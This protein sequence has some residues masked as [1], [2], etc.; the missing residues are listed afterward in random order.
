MKKMAKAAAGQEFVFT[1][2]VAGSP[3]SFSDYLLS[4]L[5]LFAGMFG[6]L[7]VFMSTF[8]VFPADF[9]VLVLLLVPLCLLS[10][11]CWQNRKL[12]FP[13]LLV[14]G[15]GITAVIL[16]FSGQVFSGAIEVYAGV[17][18]VMNG[19][20]YAN[21]A[22][23]YEPVGSGSPLLFWVLVSLVLSLL[24]G[25][26]FIQARSGLL[27]ILVTAP[28]LFFG[29]AF[30]LVPENL[31]FYIL[32][33]SFYVA[34]FSSSR[35]LR[36]G[37][38]GPSLSVGAATLL[39]LFSVLCFLFTQCVFK[40]EEY[41]RA[42]WLVDLRAGTLSFVSSL[43]SG[44][45]PD[46]PFR[47]PG[48]SGGGIAGG[49]LGQIGRLEYTGETAL[50]VTRGVEAPYY[51]R[52]YVGSRYEGNQW[53]QTQ[54]ASRAYLQR[55][56]LS[57]F[58]ETGRDF[59]S[60]G[61][62]ITEQLIRSGSMSV[63]METD[64]VRVEVVNAPGQYRYTPYGS[65]S[66][67]RLDPYNPNFMQ[68]LFQSTGNSTYVEP[69]TLLR[70]TQTGRLVQYS[71]YLDYQHSADYRNAF[72]TVVASLPS[73]TWSDQ[74]ANYVSAY[75][76]VD[77][78]YAPRTRQQYQYRGWQQQYTVAEFVDRVRTDVQS[79]ATYSLEP[80][81][82]PEGEDFVD[83]FLFQSHEG[84]CVHFASAVAVIL[85]MNGV[86]AR[87][88]EGYVLPVSASYSGTGTFDVTD[89]QAHAWVEVYF[90][91]FGW[92]PFEVTPG[93]GLT[94]A[95]P[96][97]GSVTQEG[98]STPPESSSSSSSQPEGQPGG[99]DGP[100]DI[101]VQETGGPSALAV[102]LTVACGILVLVLLLLLSPVLADRRREKHLQGDRAPAVC[103]QYSL[104]V[105]RLLGRPY[106]PG[107]AP[108]QYARLVDGAF[109]DQEKDGPSFTQIMQDILQAEYA[110][111]PL[112]KEQQKELAQFPQR[113]Q[114]LCRSQVSGLKW[115]YFRFI[116]HV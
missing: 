4:V 13:F 61:M 20:G 34:A 55:E 62:Y 99:A 28:F 48:T 80:G 14:S 95:D 31:L 70:D 59:A 90:E 7:G 50:R 44:E 69:V 56:S 93:A 15:V 46:G 73:G 84:Y 75:G 102:W 54:T 77:I 108:L 113:L 74:Y 17:A 53:N 88:V 114:R 115:F 68:D 42:G 51:L 43:F 66:Y 40:Q 24:L 94:E 78:R 30:G 25:M 1:A 6:A 39:M 29:L 3:T 105:F 96:T 27:C 67:L 71:P 82:L 36:R 41:E 98:S 87:Y 33:I 57:M 35:R 18:S 22:I 97:G 16:L 92:I 58:Q 5:L 79:V 32:L 26:A 63:S 111:V 76:G 2:E 81:M 38:T 104:R 116:R 37:R 12:T 110:D 83:Y 23:P 101:T 65:S 60:P 64:E 109:P 45:M 10:A 100:D 106:Q 47:V 91:N 86:P 19:A 107:T 11:L 85:K 103:K 49:V 72:D 8:S 112:G 89:R 21:L 52:A 9:G